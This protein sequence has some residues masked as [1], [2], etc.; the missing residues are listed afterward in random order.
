MRK[1]NLGKDLTKKLLSLLGYK[2][3]KIPGK[4]G[5]ATP[6]FQ[7]F[8]IDTIFDIGANVGQYAQSLR[9]D[10]YNGRI[11]SFEAVPEVHSILRE[12]ARS[13]I[14]W[15][16]GENVALSD[17]VGTAVFYKSHNSVSSS[18]L[19]PTSESMA[20]CPETKICEEIHVP[21]RLFD[22][23]FEFYT[24]RKNRVMLKIDAQGAELKVLEG[25]KKSLQKI[26]LIQV[27]LN[28]AEVYEGQPAYFEVDDALRMRNFNLVDILP[29]F[30][31]YQDGRL[32]QYDA[33][34][35]QTI[36]DS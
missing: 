3:A 22:E 11:I 6:L 20:A 16:I 2:I 28:V 21:V 36:D 33:V 10:G 17:F 31:N 19:T 30:R 29:G 7:S 12:N 26:S 13:D 5:T 14:N 32:L 35:A 18:L 23:Y 34:Y 15:L 9:N 1:D 8:N 4:R 25:A 27:E 24:N